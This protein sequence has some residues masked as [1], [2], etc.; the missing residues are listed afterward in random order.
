MEIP[1]IG[2]TWAW[3]YLTLEIPG[4]GVAARAPN[5]VNNK[6]EECKQLF[7]CSRVAKKSGG[8]FIFGTVISC[9]WTIHKSMFWYIE[10]DDGVDEEV[11]IAELEERQQLYL[12]HESDDEV[13]NSK[14]P[15]TTTA[16]S[17]HPICENS[18]HGNIPTIPQ[19]GSTG[20]S[21]DG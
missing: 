16:P 9:R 8:L 2:D 19:M 21:K 14:Q 13:G 6:N 20:W 11:L 18:I 1:D 4:S 17:T 7:S 15:A 10:Y 5:I 12:E 3:R